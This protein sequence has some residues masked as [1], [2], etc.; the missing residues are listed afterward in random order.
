MTEHAV[1]TTRITPYVAALSLLPAAMTVVPPSLIDAD[2]VRSPM[3]FAL[4]VSGS[5]IDAELAA[6]RASIDQ[7][8]PDDPFPYFSDVYFALNSPPVA[9]IR[10]RVVEGPPSVRFVEDNDDFAYIDFVE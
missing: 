5:Q 8:L 1:R 2:E 9:L 3:S 6:V 4:S 10:A 7:A